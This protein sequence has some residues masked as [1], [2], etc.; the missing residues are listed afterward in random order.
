MHAIQ[1]SNEHRFVFDVDVLDKH[2]IPPGP[3]GIK[4]VERRRRANRIT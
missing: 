3:G 2:S 4:H 1:W